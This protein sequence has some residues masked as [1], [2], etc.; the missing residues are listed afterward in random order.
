MA[1]HV[2]DHRNHARGA[3]VAAD[4]PGNGISHPDGIAIGTQETLLDDVALAIAG[5]DVRDEA[6]GLVAILR[7]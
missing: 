4:D 5:E 3:S 2:L 1:G 7:G 6:G